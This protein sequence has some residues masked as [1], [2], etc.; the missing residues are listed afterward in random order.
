MSIQQ[1]QIGI[2]ITWS[3]CPTKPEHDN[4]NLRAP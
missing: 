4:T 2:G 3:G 1:R